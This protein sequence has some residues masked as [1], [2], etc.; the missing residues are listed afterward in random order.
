MSNSD[1]DKVM[2]RLNEMLRLKGYPREYYINL[3]AM[4]RDL[5]VFIGSY[6]DMVDQIN[7]LGRMWDDRSE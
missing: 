5:S 7:S 4:K 1:K 3:N 2:N 6:D